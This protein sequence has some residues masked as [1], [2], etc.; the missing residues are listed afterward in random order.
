MRQRLAITPD[1]GGIA[2][3]VGPDRPLRRYSCSPLMTT[4]QTTD[5]FDTAELELGLALAAEAPAADVEQDQ[6]IWTPE[7]GDFN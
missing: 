1:L 3:A 6:P 7:D 5:A 4:N 2:R